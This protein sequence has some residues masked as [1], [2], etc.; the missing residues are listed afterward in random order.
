VAYHDV[1]DVARAML[2]RELKDS[3]RYFPV[4]H[5]FNNRIRRIEKCLENCKTLGEQ[6]DAI[7][8]ELEASNAL[9]L[10]LRKRRKPRGPTDARLRKEYETLRLQLAP[11]LR[12]RKTKTRK[13]IV[14]ELRKLA[15]KATD[16]ALRDAAESAPAAAACIL[17][18]N[19]HHLSP[20][21]IRNRT[22]K[23]KKQTWSPPSRVGA[24]FL[25]LHL[26][27]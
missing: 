23:A 21:T 27:R 7:D 20:N 18:G 5:D 22:S 15:P 16:K 4:L 24:L 11:I 26:E 12:G 9:N 6:A 17:L 10:D 25:S 1:L 8:R 3:C 19:R 13:T 14:K 2:F